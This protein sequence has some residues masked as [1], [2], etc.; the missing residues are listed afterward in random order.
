MSVVDQVQESGWGAIFLFIYVAAILYAWPFQLDRLAF[1][2]AAVTP[3]LILVFLTISFNDFLM[4]LFAGSTVRET[5]REIKKESKEDEFYWDADVGTKE[6]IDEMDQKAH[7]HL[8][9]ILS[10]IVIA[11]TLPLV[12]GVRFGPLP[13]LVAVLG[14]LLVG[15][16]LSYRSYTKLREVIKSSVKLYTSS[17]E[18]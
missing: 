6:S 1:A 9:T 15:Y 3:S 16:L 8:V 2:V 13:S 14:S 12:I 7:R 11:V 17:N 4:E 10:G 5:F 18:D